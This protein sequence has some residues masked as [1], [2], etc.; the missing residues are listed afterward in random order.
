M[1]EEP[2]SP[3]PESGLSQEILD[4]FRHHPLPTATIWRVQYMPNSMGVWDA[5]WAATK[6]L[7]RESMEDL[8]Q[9]G[10]Y[11]PEDPR[12]DY[13]EMTEPKEVTVELSPAGLLQF[14]QNY[15]VDQSE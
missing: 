9:E 4:K 8:A 3:K 11:V 15:A 2:A 14:A 12:G 13:H 1:T 7:A 10:Y 5:V 6:A